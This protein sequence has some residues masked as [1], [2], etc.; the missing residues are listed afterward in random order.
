M[1][2][3]PE[4]SVSP[5]GVIWRAPV[6]KCPKNFSKHPK[7]FAKALKPYVKKGDKELVDTILNDL[8]EKRAIVIKELRS[9]NEG[10]CE[11]AESITEKINAYLSLLNG[12]SDSD[13]ED[14]MKRSEMRNV[15]SSMVSFG[16]SDTLTG[17]KT[18][19]KY[20]DIE[21]NKVLLW[22]GIAIM[23]NAVATIDP[24]FTKK[25]MTKE[26]LLPGFKSLITAAGI[27]QYVASEKNT[28]ET[29]G[30]D[31]TDGLFPQF[32]AD[33]CMALAQEITIVRAMQGKLD[34][35]AIATYCANSSTRYQRLGDMLNEL[36]HDAAAWKKEWSA[37]LRFKTSY[38]LVLANGYQACKRYETE[39]AT[40]CCL[41][42]KNFE[43]AEAELKTTGEIMIAYNK[44]SKSGKLPA[45][46]LQWATKFLAEKS[47]KPK[48]DNNM[49]YFK[50]V[51]ETGDNLGDGKSPVEGKAI[52]WK[53]VNTDPCWTQT[54]KSAFDPNA[55]PVEEKKSEEEEPSEETPMKPKSPNNKNRKANLF[56]NSKKKEKGR[57]R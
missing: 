47:T 38:Y 5:E 4:V 27:L 7:N 46:T 45:D 19:V 54:A 11:D 40:N 30:P 24:C 20:T 29:S 9:L 42:I 49:A 48:S 22:T 2:E 3:S 33:H 12:F 57:E 34:C 52:K 41:A 44:V 32:C 21:A 28:A 39:D 23:N 43:L 14:G 25:E 53:N 10:T 31:L 16:W 15:M 6:I 18:M 8:T 17:S 26:V 55:E 50:T 37:Y 36:S 56:G 35:G 1:S 13:G 51:P